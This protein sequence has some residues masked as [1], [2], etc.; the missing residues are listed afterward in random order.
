MPRISDF[1]GEIIGTFII[2]F[3]GCG[4]GAAATL[5]SLHVGLF[6]IALVWGMAVVLAIYATRHLSHAH[7]NPAVSIAMVIGG[8]MKL[9]ELPG[10]LAAQFLGAFMA[11][12]V[13]YFIFS[14][15]IQQFEFVHHI[16]RG[17]PA[18][19]NTAMLF[20]EFYPNPSYAL[21]APISMSVAFATESMGTFA[22][23]FLVFSLTNGCNIGRPDHSLVPIFIGLAVTVII[24]VIAPITQSCL[25]PARDLSPRIVTMLAGWG[26]AALP[27]H[28]YGFII[29]YVCGPIFGGAL[30]A[31][32]FTRV[33]EPIMKQKAQHNEQ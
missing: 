9:R 3:F 18:S 32:L 30:A 6:D 20:G 1:I 15:S 23:I 24:S 16:V 22:L 10:Y 28:H 29:V 14:S 8:R 25:N 5:F 11:A 19:I 21:N 13:V 12:G 17:T 27:D 7:F 31:S 26:D 33:I 2:V 4:A